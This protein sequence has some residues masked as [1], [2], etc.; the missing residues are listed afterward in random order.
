M[1]REV[2]GRKP[3]VVAHAGLG[4]VPEDRQVFPDLTVE[5]NLVIAE[6]RAS[7]VATTGL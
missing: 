2:S 6:K 3:H 4:Y 7:T 5:D 1:G